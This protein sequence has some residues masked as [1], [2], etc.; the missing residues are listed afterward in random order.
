MTLS[1]NIPGRLRRTMI[2]QWPNDFSEIEGTLIWNKVLFREC[3]E[4]SCRELAQWTGRDFCQPVLNKKSLGHREVIR[5]KCPGMLSDSV[6]LLHDNTHTAPKKSRIAANFQIGSLE[7][8]P[9]HP[10]F[11]T[12]LGSKLLSGTMFFSD[13]D[14]KKQLLRTA[15]MDRT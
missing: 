2:S 7:P 14:V 13:S 3:C 5:R 6:I 4:N 15:P 8:P 9:H 12:N 1:L 10:R 11:G